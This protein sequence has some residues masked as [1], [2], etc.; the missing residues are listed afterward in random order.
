MYAV[1]AGSP[2]TNE[3][4][5]Y[6]CLFEKQKKMYHK[7]MSRNFSWNAL[8]LS[9]TQSGENNRSVTLLTEEEG[10]IYAT[11][12]GGGKSKLKSLVS[13]FNRGMAYIYRD[14]TKNN[15]KITDFD[16]KMTHLSF[17]ENLFKSYAASFAAEIVLKTKCAGSPQKSYTL[18]NGFLD[19]MEL[20]SEDESRTGLLR[21]IWRYLDLMGLRPDCIFCCQCGKDFFSSPFNMQSLKNGAFYDELNSGFVCQDCGGTRNSFFLPIE[22][23]TYLEA[24]SR[25]PPKEVR[26]MPLDSETRRIL[27]DFCYTIIEKS[28]GLKFLSLATGISIL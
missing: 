3:E 21:F 18:L 27:K 8:V 23:L 5:F 1:Y 17:R 6:S 10:I 20:S 26:K 25:L 16:P 28:T 7:N 12:F 24:V 9:V 4:V 15:C 22:A 2:N 14:E 19:G 13:P 11:L